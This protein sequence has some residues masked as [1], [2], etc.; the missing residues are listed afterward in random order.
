M[1][2]L[3]RVQ[4]V[5]GQE[6]GDRRGKKAV[7]VLEERIQESEVRRENDN[8]RHWADKNCQPRLVV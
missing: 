2:N 6:T 1:H 5:R 4:D 8:F 3:C 7:A